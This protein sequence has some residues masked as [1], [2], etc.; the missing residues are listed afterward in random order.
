M[1]MYLVCKPDVALLY[2][3][4]KMRT[5]HLRNLF[6]ASGKTLNVNNGLA[7]SLNAKNLAKKL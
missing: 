6:S 2:S 1:L 3:R 7:K 5:N 4:S